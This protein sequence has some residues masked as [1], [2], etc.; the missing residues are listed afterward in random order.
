[1][2]VIPKTKKRV[3]MFIAKTFPNR[4]PRLYS[5]LDHPIRVPVQ[6]AAYELTTRK[7]LEPEDRVLDVGFG[8]GYGMATMAARAR[9]LFGIDIDRRAVS[10]GQELVEQ[11]P[12]IVEVRY[13]DGRTIPY[14]DDSFDAVTCIDVLEHVQDYGQALEEMVRVARRIVF[15]STPN[16]RPENTRAD[17]RPKNRWHIREW[18]YEELDSV[19][20]ERLDVHVDWN[21]LNG[22]WDGPFACTSTVSEDT[23]SLAPALTLLLS[24]RKGGIDNRS[25]G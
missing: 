7:Y 24:K 23:L 15:V 4:F 5:V 22:P 11:V 21:C 14:S 13:Y 16:R 17:G 3:R 6:M 9:E 10:R 8:L 1:M 12:Q 20:R 25:E 2:Q 18:S 19:L